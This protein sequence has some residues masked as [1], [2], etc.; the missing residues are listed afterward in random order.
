MKRY[1]H[2]DQLILIITGLFLWGWMR[3][4]TLSVYNERGSI[5]GINFNIAAFVG[6]CLFSLLLFA[7]L[8]IFSYLLKKRLGKAESTHS[9]AIFY[10]P[11][12]VAFVMGLYFIYRIYRD[13]TVVYP[14]DT[15][16]TYFW[17]RV[18][19]RIFYLLMLAFA[20]ITIC[21][22]KQTV[23]QHW[24]LRNTTA[25][26]FALVNGALLYAPAPTSDVGGGIQHIDAYV[27]SITNVLH[28]TPYSPTNLSIY[29]HY[30]LIYAPL[31]KLLGGS[32]QAIALSI[33]VV[34]VLTYLA[35]FLAANPAVKSD[36]IYLLTV[37]AITGT[38]TVLNRRGQY[39]QINPHRLLMPALTLL[40]ISIE[41]FKLRR[42]ES[43]KLLIL[44]VILGILAITWNLETGLFS[45]AIL[46]AHHFYLMLG[47]KG[48]SVKQFLLWCLYAVLFLC[49]CFMGAW[50]L[51]GVYNLL[52]G[53]SFGSVRT[54]I[55]PIMS[56]TYQVSNLRLS[57]PGVN[58]VYVFEIL[59]FVLALLSSLKT[60]L[61]DKDQKNVHNALIFATALSGCASMVYFLNRAAVGNMS[62]QHAQAALLL[63]LLSDRLFTVE[64][65]ELVSG[66][67][68]SFS[69]FPILLKGLIYLSLCY[70]VMASVTTLPTT[71][72]YR[73]TSTWN[74]EAWDTMLTE[75][76][77]TVPR[78][79]VASG[80]GIP[81]IY[82]ELGWDTGC[83]LIDH[84]DMNPPT[85]EVR[86][87][88]FAESNEVL[89]TVALDENVWT[90]VR[91][92]PLL[93][94]DVIRYAIKK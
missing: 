55:Y 80:I 89:T 9:P 43:K 58:A 33:A 40:L 57:L 51:C 71:V 65:S 46:A 64:K 12:S 31:V 77:E 22:V 78:D 85:R 29:G 25:L 32:Y 37:L 54:Y 83:H 20:V 38:T 28:G 41:E 27:T 21:L 76:E 5:H 52:T 90:V 82:Q 30:G 88:L 15:V 6:G 44:E 39:Y 79:T 13:E 93:N 19:I 11:Y 18:P 35:F 49:I 86:D 14:G 16:A 8:H 56:E 74:T 67:K 3:M 73:T 66:L 91:E 50:A 47:R 72:R 68:S 4:A 26:V 1:S 61:M 70:F 10:F 87:Q 69:V 17:Q 92:W 34:A 75:I 81:A 42:A 2:A 48:F 59:L 60:Q 23:K 63:G 53:G 84:L 36:W 24:L 7:S 94:G 62:M 45:V